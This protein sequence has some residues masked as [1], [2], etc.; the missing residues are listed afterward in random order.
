VF[1]RDCRSFL[2]I[3]AGN[4]FPTQI[5]KNKQTNKQTKN[6]IATNQWIWLLSDLFVSEKWMQFEEVTLEPGDPRILPYERVPRESAESEREI[7]LVHFQDS[8]TCLV[9]A[10]LLFFYPS[11]SLALPP[12][13]GQVTPSPTWRISQVDR[14]A[15]PLWRVLIKSLCNPYEHQRHRIFSFPLS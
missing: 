4:E 6:Q 13:P 9:S 14:Q 2:A 1:W 12:A 15:L 11:L 3:C 7:Q 10:L 8:H 5:Y